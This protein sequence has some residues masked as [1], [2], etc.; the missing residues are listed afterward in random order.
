[1]IIPQMQEGFNVY[2]SPKSKVWHQGM[3]TRSKRNTV[4]EQ[5]YNA[6]IYHQKWKAKKEV[7]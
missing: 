6:Q 7:M 1:M 3:Q 5:V 2:I 4:T